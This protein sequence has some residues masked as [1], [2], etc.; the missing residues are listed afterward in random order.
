VD[1]PNL[2]GYVAQTTRLAIAGAP[3][4][5]P[6]SLAQQLGLGLEIGLPLFKAAVGGQCQLN[7]IAGIGQV[8]TAV[9]WLLQ[10]LAWTFATLAVAG[11]TGLIRKT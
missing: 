8:F 4:G 5:T 10:A 7:S 11:Y 9:S 2:G 1:N 3:S 6:C